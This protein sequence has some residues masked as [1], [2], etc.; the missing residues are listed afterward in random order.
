M[1]MCYS[2]SVSDHSV[3]KCFKLNKSIFDW[4]RGTAE[5]FAINYWICTAA[6]LISAQTVSS[7]SDSFKRIKNESI[8]LCEVS[9]L[10][11]NWITKSKTERKLTVGAEDAYFNRW[12]FALYFIFNKKIHSGEGK[13]NNRRLCFS[14][15][16]HAEVDHICSI[17][18]NIHSGRCMNVERSAE[19]SLPAKRLTAHY[20]SKHEFIKAEV[21]NK[22]PQRSAKTKKE[23]VFSLLDPKCH[24]CFPW[25]C[26]VQPRGAQSSLMLLRLTGSIHWRRVR[27]PKVVY[28]WGQ[29]ID[30]RSTGVH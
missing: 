16:L 18:V 21:M 26:W 20:S 29:L 22:R 25:T 17:L 27:S 30:F 14:Y 10:K 13:G 2:E 4:Q 28:L 6:I 12:L 9:K 15:S 7:F 5:Y 23:S 19:R 11:L 24:C 8:Y 3:L 1:L